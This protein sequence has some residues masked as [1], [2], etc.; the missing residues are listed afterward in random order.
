MVIIKKN[1]NSNKS[2][3]KI[4]KGLDYIFLNIS[5]EFVLLN[6]CNSF[7]KIILLTMTLISSN[8]I[9]HNSFQFH[10]R[11]VVEKIQ[12]TCIIIS[13]IIQI[14]HTF[15][16]CRSISGC[17][18]PTRHT[19]KRNLTEWSREIAFKETGIFGIFLP[20]NILQAFVRSY[21]S[22]VWIQYACWSILRPL[23]C[24]IGYD[25]HFDCSPHLIEFLIR[26][27]SMRKSTGFFCNKRRVL[28]VK[29]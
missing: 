14:S 11:T 20:T 6:F 10:T 8:F 26:L 27:W 4:I 29:V 24:Q 25:T 22:S 7:Y 15:N 9:L 5:N 28:N 23:R 3:C 18:W 13:D 1:I 17:W 12:L 2:D 21:F 19:I 16:N